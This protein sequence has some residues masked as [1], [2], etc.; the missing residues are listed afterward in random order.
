MPKESRI[1][2]FICIFMD[3][4]F[5]YIHFFLIMCPNTLPGSSKIQNCMNGIYDSKLKGIAKSIE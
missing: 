2:A 4:R 1:N 3:S 5:V